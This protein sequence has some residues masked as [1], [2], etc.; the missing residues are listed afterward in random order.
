MPAELSGVRGRS[1]NLTATVSTTNVQMVTWSF[2]S[3]SGS[4]VP[5][6]TAT[7][8]G[9]KVHDPYPGRVTYYRSTY[10]LEIQSLIPSDSGTYTLNVVDT[11]LDQV[12]GQ[13]RLE[14]L[15]ALNLFVFI[16][17]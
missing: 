6:C 11:N 9:E 8:Q 1:L 12:V 16:F 7:T 2:I 13:T 4:T 5:I 14:V 15:G 10:T 17:C 3:K